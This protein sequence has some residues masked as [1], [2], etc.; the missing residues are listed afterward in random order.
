MA[1]RAAAVAFRNSRISTSPNPIRTGVFNR[2]VAQLTRL[3]N[4]K[5]NTSF[6]AGAVG[7]AALQHIIT[8][9]GVL[10]R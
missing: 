8:T 1:R 2:K 4:P 3:L 10:V 6:K 9:Q 5:R 7:A